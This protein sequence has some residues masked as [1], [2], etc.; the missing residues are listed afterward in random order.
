MVV[1]HEFGHFISAKLLGVRVNEFSVG[2]GPQII[3]WQGKETKYSIRLIPFGGFCAMEGEDEGSKDPR[4]FCNKA[5]WKRF[6]IVS[7]GAVFNIIFGLS[8]MMIYFAP[9]GA[10]ATNTV[11]SFTENAVSQQSGLEVGDEIISI[12]GRN[13]LTVTEI[14]YAFS[15]V[16]DNKV[17]LVV[18][19]NGV[20]TEL[21]NVEFQMEEI[22]GVKYFKRD[23]NFQY[24]EN[25]FGTF[26]GQSVRYTVS[27]GRVV[28]FS[29]VDLIRGRFSLNEVS[30]P[31]GV[32][33]ALGQAAKRGLDTLLPMLCLI[34][35]NLGVFNL[36]P[37]PALDGGRLV[38]I[39]YEMIFRKPVSQKYESV[40]HGVGFLLLMLF[41]AFV[42]LKDILG[43]F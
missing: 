36:L 23:F 41:L 32:A 31:V 11:A 22:E 5:A 27:Y 30:G 24:K 34:T 1:I 6:I 10:I 33:T 29:L 2:F 26:I 21:K 39:L 37:V 3:K 17:D 18:K 16:P 43:F 15:S 25:T 8:L 20:K 38:F 9:A 13:C 35:V 14:G 19:R 42:T 28:W 12:D 4:A 40:I 7:A